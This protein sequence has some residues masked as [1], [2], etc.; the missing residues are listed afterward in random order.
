MECIG[1]RVC[2]LEAAKPIVLFIN[3]PD[4]IFPYFVFPVITWKGVIE[5]AA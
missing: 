2:R 3:I 5:Y 1:K 4:A